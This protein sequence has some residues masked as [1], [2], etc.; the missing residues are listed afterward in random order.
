M[1]GFRLAIN[2]FSSIGFSQ[3]LLQVTYAEL[4]GWK[5]QGTHMYKTPFI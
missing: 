1:C 3:N 2:I 5:T 4:E